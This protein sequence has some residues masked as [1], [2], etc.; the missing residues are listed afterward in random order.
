MTSVPVCW[1][2][3]HTDGNQLLHI[4]VRYDESAT[5]VAAEVMLKDGERVQ[6]AARPNDGYADLYDRVWKHTRQ[7]LSEFRTYL[8]E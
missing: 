2:A 4:R 8:E 7:R 6:I 5:L 1:I 3:P